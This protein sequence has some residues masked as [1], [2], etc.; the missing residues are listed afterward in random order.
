MK[1]GVV[2]TSFSY[3]TTPDTPATAFTGED[4]QIVVRGVNNDQIWHG[5]LNTA[6]DEWSG[7]NLL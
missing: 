1:H 7:W 2:G 3:G 4:L 6:N 5:T